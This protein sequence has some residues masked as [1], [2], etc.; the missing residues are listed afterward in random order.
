MKEIE[1]LH[2]KIDAM[3]KVLAEASAKNG[4]PVTCKGKGCF[5]CCYEPV[6]CSSAEVNHLIEVMTVDQKAAVTERLKVSLKAVEARGLFNEPMPSVMRWLAMRLPC[7]LLE[8]GSCSV[9]ESRPV[10]CRSHM[11]VGPAEWCSTNRSEQKY[12]MAKEYSAKSGQEIIMAH[13]KLGN[14]LIQDNLLVLLAKELIGDYPH[15]AS[16]ETIVFDNK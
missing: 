2:R 1:E 7:P 13:L 12:P 9:Y 5:A 3:D 8:N 4:K 10:S 14:T 11:A 16:G 6:Y 15:T